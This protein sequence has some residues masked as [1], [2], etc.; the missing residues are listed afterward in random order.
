MDYHANQN[1]TIEIILESDALVL[2]IFFYTFAVLDSLAILCS[3][4]LFYCFACLPELHREHYA[5]LTAIYLLISAF[6][7]STIDVPMLLMYFQNYHQIASLKDPNSFCIFW[8]ILDYIFFTINLWLIAL[9]SLE[10]YIMIF[11]KQ[12]VMRSKKRRFC[13]YYALVIF[14]V[15]FISVWY[16]YF[17]R[18]YPCV[19]PQSFDFTQVFCGSPCYLVEASEIFV[20]FD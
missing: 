1:V 18:F 5:H 7:I 2:Q 8:R 4:L 19:E 16:I 17:I 13:A 14:M 15:V 9:F 20:N 6:L 3:L 11:F 10:R 12:V